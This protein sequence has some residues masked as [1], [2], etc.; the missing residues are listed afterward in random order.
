MATP[1]LLTGIPQNVLTLA[2]AKAPE[3]RCGLQEAL[4][5]VNSNNDN[6]PQVDMLEAALFF[7]TANSQQNVELSALEVYHLLS[8]G[9]NYAK[10][11]T[12]AS[13]QG[14]VMKYDDS[15][16]MN[17]DRERFLPHEFD[18]VASNQITQDARELCELLFNAGRN[19][20]VSVQ[21][22]LVVMHS[23]ARRMAGEHEES[24]DPDIFPPVTYGSLEGAVRI[25][26]QV[27]GCAPIRE[28]PRGPRVRGRTN[29]L[30]YSAGFMPIQEILWINEHIIHVPNAGDCN[31]GVA[32]YWRIERNPTSVQHSDPFSDMPIRGSEN[33]PRG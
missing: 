13:A 6:S 8:R 23:A 31:W 18:P 10:E 19:T 17:A 24:G 2:P 33:I 1:I 26:D 32:P 4:G 7:R 27:T 16:Y 25:D 12:F 5:E 9:T 20:A 21:R 14:W 22:F 30:S 3:T 29:P 11:N 15:Y 28:L